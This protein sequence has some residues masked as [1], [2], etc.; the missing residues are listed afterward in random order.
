MYYLTKTFEVPI[1]H[2][3]SKHLGKC[4][5]FH[6]HNLYIEVTIKS[7]YLNN[8]DMVMDFS[9]LKELVNSIIYSWDHGMFINQS[10]LEMVKDLKCELHVFETDPTSEVLCKK[11][12]EDLQNKILKTEEWLNI[13]VHSISIWETKNSKSTYQE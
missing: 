11:L 9:K 2:R 1:S 7:R 8:N 13:F 4:Q 5:L 3:L 12:F 6:G 10:D